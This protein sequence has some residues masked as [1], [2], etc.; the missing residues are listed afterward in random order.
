M[1]PVGEPGDVAGLDQE[2]CG[3]GRADP[4][5]GSQRGAGGLQRRGQLLARGFL[6]LVDPLQVADQLGGDPPPGLPGRSRGRTRAGKTL[7]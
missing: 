5:Q 2:P 4:F 6:A 1:P 3:A 7:A